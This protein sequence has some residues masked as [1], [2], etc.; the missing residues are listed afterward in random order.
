LP[1]FLQAVHG[2][3]DPEED[4]AFSGLVDL[5]V[6]KERKTRQDV[7]RVRV[8]VDANVLRVEKWSAEVKIGEVERAEVGILRDDSIEGAVEGNEGSD[9]GRGRARRGKAVTTRSSADASIDVVLERTKVT[10]GKER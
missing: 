9:V 10:W 4:V 7:R 2:A 1:S 6:G 8:D 5:D 3:V